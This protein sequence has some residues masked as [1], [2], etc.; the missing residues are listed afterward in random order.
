M[1]QRG[2]S[3]GVFVRRTE[4]KERGEGNQTVLQEAQIPGAACSLGAIM[5]L[6]FSIDA[7]E[8]LLDCANGDELGLRNLF[9]GKT[10]GEK[11]QH[12]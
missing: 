4:L 6:E 9:V 7:L 3:R 10:G 12:L 8:M 5:H 11:P 1:P 2:Y